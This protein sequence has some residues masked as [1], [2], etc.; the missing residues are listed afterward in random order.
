MGFIEDYLKTYDSAESP[1]SF[2]Y[3]SAIAAMAS[4]LR[5]NVYV[6]KRIYK[7]YPN[8]YIMFVAKSGLRKGYPVKQA[9][10]LVEQT[11]VVKVISGRNSIQ[12]ILQELSRQWTIPSGK[13]MKDAQAL[14]VNDELDSLLINDPQ[15]QTILTALYDSFY[16]KDWTNTLK[17]DGRETLRDLCIT[18]LT[19]TNPTHLDNFL[20]GT[21][22]SG[23]FLGRTIIIF[24]DKKSKI[25]PLIEEND[26]VEVDLK[27]LA[28]K[29][30]E[31]AKL[32]GQFT[33]TPSAV[34]FYKKWYADFYER[35]QNN[36][37]EDQTGTAERAGD[38]ILKLSMVLS[39]NDCNTLLIDKGHI[40]RSVD[41]FYRSARDS[42]L[43][44]EGKGKSLESGAVKTVLGYLLQRPDYSAYRKQ[45][46]A[47]RYGDISATEL[48]SAIDTLDQAGLIEVMNDKDEGPF[49]KLPDKYVEKLKG[50]VLWK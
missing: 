35:L 7:L 5:K 2:F 14:V 49:Y 38:T 29:L 16:H 1:T 13:V 46:L 15:A 11:E 48:A 33:F 31:I 42:K 18:M 36:E 28:D 3:W 4:V 9:Q 50:K 22:I 39:V 30:A 23:G 26:A 10:K 17:K 32:V 21:S 34:S 43:V 45:I 40:E 37:I 8:L 25:N 27:P 19:A 44:T 12:S 24:E 41:L 47:S 20:D 6:N